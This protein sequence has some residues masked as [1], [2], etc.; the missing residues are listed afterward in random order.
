MAVVG[1]LVWWVW[2]LVGVGDS[3]VGVVR[4]E[5]FQSRSDGWSA[6]SSAASTKN[7]LP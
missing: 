6:G 3:E 4:E 1:W 5:I 7:T 2:V